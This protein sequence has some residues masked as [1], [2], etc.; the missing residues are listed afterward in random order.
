MRVYEGHGFRRVGVR[1]DY[2]P[3]GQGQREDALV[4]SLKL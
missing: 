3:D 1:K 4:M 2:Y